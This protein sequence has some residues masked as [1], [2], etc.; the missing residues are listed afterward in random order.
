MEIIRVIV[1][2]GSLEFGVSNHEAAE[3]AAESIR[4]RLE[5][6]DVIV[7]RPQGAGGM[8]EMLQIARTLTIDV[9]WDSLVGAAA[10]VM[11]EALRQMLTKRVNEVR[12]QRD[13]GER[14]EL[15][16]DFIFP[17]G[18]TVQEKEGARRVTPFRV[19]IYGPNRNVLA[20][21]AVV[22]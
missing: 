3:E 18:T 19:T 5:G 16:R 22:C 2:I 17:P 7:H 1:P 21:I 8:Y 11:L 4:T 10:G 6:Y 12:S 13:K 20:V 15:D 14:R 9:P